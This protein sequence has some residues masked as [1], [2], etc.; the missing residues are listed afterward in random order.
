[1][2]HSK[3]LWCTAKAI[4]RGCDI[5]EGKRRYSFERTNCNRISGEMA[6]FS[7]LV[8]DVVRFDPPL[9]GGSYA[10]RRGENHRSASRIGSRRIQGQSQRKEMVGSSKTFMIMVDTVEGKKWEHVLNAD[11]YNLPV[12]EGKTD[13]ALSWELTQ[14][15]PKAQTLMLLKFPTLSLVDCGKNKLM[16]LF[17]LCHFSNRNPQ[18]SSINDLEVMSKLIQGFQLL[19]GTG[20]RFCSSKI[21]FKLQTSFDK[22]PGANFMLR[23]HITYGKGERGIPGNSLKFKTHCQQKQRVYLLGRANLVQITS[24]VLFA[25]YC[26]GAGF[27]P[28]RTQRVAAA[29]DSQIEKIERCDRISYLMELEKA[30]CDRTSRR[31]GASGSGSAAVQNCLCRNILGYFSDES[32]RENKSKLYIP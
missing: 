12:S 17:R 20:Q 7:E 8:N 15:T 28:V 10:L 31:R 25:S 27:Y 21:S 26:I 13:C 16:I 14:Q 19:M 1:M 11:K 32:A 18:D 2:M 3:K 9:F 30:G 5:E 6:E 29:A 22:F 24:P 4:D 23:L